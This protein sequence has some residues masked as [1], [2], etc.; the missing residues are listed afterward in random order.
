V[1]LEDLFGTYLETIQKNAKEMK[2][3]ADLVVVHDPQPA[4]LVMHSAIYGKVLWRCHIDTSA[5]NE[6][7]WRFLLPYINQYSGAIFT[8]PEFVSPGLQIPTYQIT[9][10]IDPLAVKNWLWTAE[11]AQT[12]LAPLFH[13]HDMDPDRP[14]LAAVSRYDIHKNQPTILKAFNRLREQRQS[15]AP[16]YLVFLGNTATDDPEGE[17]V[18]KRL[19][20]TAGD[21]PDVKF[22]VN[23]QNNDQ[24]VGALMQAARGFVH[25]STKEGFGLVVSEALWHGTPVIGS[26]VG[27]ITRQV[28]DGENGFVVDP[29]DVE[30][31]AQKMAFFLD[32]PQVSEVMGRRGWGHVRRHFLLPELV[33]KHLALIRYYHKVDVTP[34]TFRLNS[35]TYKEILDEL[36][37]YGHRANQ[38]RIAARSWS[39]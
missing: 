20:E 3:G 9:P 24:V 14:I 4:A 11:E 30:T 36:R 39:L 22:W 5:P 31:I 18:L 6:I 27:G 33:F 34:P 26:R 37:G 28:L 8:M 2:I 10:A 29:L 1:S 12:I 25:V 13:A 17:T 7:I 19:R 35:M 38:A 32:H 16:P 21:D 23:V 15:K